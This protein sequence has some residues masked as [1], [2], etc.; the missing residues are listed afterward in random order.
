MYP[1]ILKLSQQFDQDTATELLELIRNLTEEDKKELKKGV[2]LGHFA[3]WQRGQTLFWQKGWNKGVRQKLREAME[4][5]QEVNESDV[6]PRFYLAYRKE[7]LISLEESQGLLETNIY[8][9]T[10]F[11]RMVLTTQTSTWSTTALFSPQL[12]YYSGGPRVPDYR[13]FSVPTQDSNLVVVT[14]S[15]L[16]FLILLATILLVFS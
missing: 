2:N 8:H 3:F 16:G 11:G 10:E 15:A 7:V 1:L 6:P 13:F 14:F 12:D 5:G 4:K 9:I